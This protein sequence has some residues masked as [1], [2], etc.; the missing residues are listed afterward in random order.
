MATGLYSIGVKP[1]A[2]FVGAIFPPWWSDQQIFAAVS[3]ADASI[4]RTAPLRGLIVVRPNEQSGIGKLLHSGAVM[5][6]DPIVA[7]GC[8]RGTSPR[9]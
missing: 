2:E 9:E 6:V 5:L 8:V 1:G 7:A 4:I 3:E